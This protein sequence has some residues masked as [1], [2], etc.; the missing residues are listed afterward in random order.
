[1]LLE[2][3]FCHVDRNLFHL[4][5]VI[6][7]DLVLDQLI[8]QETDLYLSMVNLLRMDKKIHKALSTCKSFSSFSTEPKPN[9][10]T[11]PLHLDSADVVSLDKCIL[12]S[13]IKALYT[14][15]L[16][17]FFFLLSLKSFGFSIQLH[18]HIHHFLFDSVEGVMIIW[19]FDRRVKYSLNQDTLRR[20]AKLP[21]GLG[22]IFSLVPP[23]YLLILHCYVL[24]S[25]LKS[26][27]N[28]FIVKLIIS[29]DIVSIIT[30]FP[31]HSLL[32]LL[33]LKLFRLQCLDLNTIPLLLYQKLV[34]F[35]NLFVTHTEL[36][37][38]VTVLFD[39]VNPWAFL[40]YDLRL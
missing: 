11:A 15:L 23:S 38:H 32:D 27:S 9:I 20:I 14:V 34:I 2:D 18:S 10:A 3:V 29:V 12:N 25:L 1:M 13:N 21:D 7:L 16:L 37:E 19:V 28:A 4:E 24:C 36:E 5:L 26:L 6:Q 8:G 22:Q 39:G 17:L 40:D 31:P 33:I 35:F 30:E